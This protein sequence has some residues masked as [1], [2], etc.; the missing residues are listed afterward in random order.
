MNRLNYKCYQGR[1][2]YDSDAYIFHGAVLYLNDVVTFQRRFIDELKQ[3]RR[4]L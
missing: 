4:I 3:A 2:A 1:F